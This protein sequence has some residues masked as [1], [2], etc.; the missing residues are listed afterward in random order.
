MIENAFV[1]GPED[2]ASYNQIKGRHMTGYIKD[3]KLY[4][5]DVEG[6]GQTIYY[7]K[8]EGE[9]IGV[10]KAESSNLTI[11]LE[12]QEVTGIILRNQPSGNLNPPDFLTR[13]ARRLEALDG[14]RNTGQRP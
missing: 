13:D 1:I 2:T 12:E 14:S 7:P 8:E 9:V 3:N 5:I 11:L 6:N 10:N 4:R